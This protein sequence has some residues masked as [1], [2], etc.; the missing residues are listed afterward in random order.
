MFIQI[1]PI[2][3]FRSSR[4]VFEVSGLTVAIGN[5]RT[6]KQIIIISFHLFEECAGCRI[7]IVD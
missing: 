1:R 7:Y 4:I 3:E 6:N 5:K 2:L